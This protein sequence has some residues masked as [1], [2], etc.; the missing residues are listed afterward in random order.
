LRIAASINGAANCTWYYAT[1]NGVLNSFFPLVLAGPITNYHGGFVMS[2]GGLVITNADAQTLSG[3]ISPTI[4]GQTGPNTGSGYLLKQ[5]AGTLT[6][7][8]SNSYVGPTTIQA[9]TLSL[10]NTNSLPGNTTL[11]LIGGTVAVYSNNAVAALE[12]NG[13]RQ[14]A[15]TW[16]SSSSG[17][18][19]T[20][21]TYFAAT[22]GIL[23]AGGS[24]ISV[25]TSSLNPSTNG[26][27]VTF[28][29]TVTGSGGDGSV[30]TGTV[31][32]YDGVTSLGAG[33]AL[34]GSGTS[35][36]W[37]L[38]TSALTVATHSITAVYGGNEVYDAST[39]S[40]LS[41]VVNSAYTPPPQPQIDVVPVGTNLLLQV[42]TVLG[43]TYVLE[44]TPSVSPTI[45]WTPIATNTGTGGTLTNTVPVEPGTP[46]LFFRY[47][48]R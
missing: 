8:G 33:T 21:D 7:S 44:S 30:P 22:S 17:A 3:P 26:D 25:V 38:T 20:N 14:A 13:V 37:I 6:L 12:F 11:K 36:Q 10:Q 39:S 41:Q 28:T 42:G 48:A 43:A 24:S 47:L 46:Q 2:P 5:G 35:N 45:V 32:F 19:H 29:N 18:S 4:D 31:T 40:A 27:S 1:S 15:G 34:G 16:G 9:G 23:T